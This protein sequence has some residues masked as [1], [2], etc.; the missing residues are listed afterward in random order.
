VVTVPAPPVDPPLPVG[1]QPDSACA[2]TSNNAIKATRCPIV[3]SP[4]FDSPM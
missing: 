3:P 1:V 4:R 2:K